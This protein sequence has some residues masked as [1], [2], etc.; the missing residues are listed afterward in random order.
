MA[1]NS[2]LFFSELSVC[3]KE[4]KALFWALISGK[5]RSV[6]EPPMQ[7]DSL[8][9]TL[10]RSLQP[11]LGLGGGLRTTDSSLLSEVFARFDNRSWLAAQTSA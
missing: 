7:Y 1:R 2:A 6:G 11:C 3:R 5:V 10:F 9:P 8:Y 4:R